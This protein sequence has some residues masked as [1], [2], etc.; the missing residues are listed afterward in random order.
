MQVLT[1]WDDDKRLFYVSPTTTVEHLQDLI[2][3]E[4]GNEVSSMLFVCDDSIVPLVSQEAFELL[5]AQSKPVIL[6][7]GR[8]DSPSLDQ[9]CIIPYQQLKFIEELEPQV[10]RFGV[11]RQAMWLRI[12]VA[13][14]TLK[15]GRFG[16]SVLKHIHK[17][18]QFRHPK[19]ALFLGTSE[20]PDSLERIIVSEFMA[21]GSLRSFLEKSG[22]GI[23]DNEPLL[24]SIASDVALGI[25]YLHT[26]NFIHGGLNCNNILLDK[27]NSAKISDFGWHKFVTTSELTRPEF[28]FSLPFLAPETISS[29]P[30]VTDKGDI[31]SFG[32]VLWHMFSGFTLNYGIHHACDIHN[33]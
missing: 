6:L 30:E 25:N 1:D 26:H 16:E 10:G 12:P 29:P 15:K 22:K 21:G 23:L 8:S 4:Y 31:Y 9:S 19:L 14:K 11:V 2:Q 27:R 7:E 24:S 17:I 3:R 20:V 32:I 5:M 18:S 28:T 33:F 13:C